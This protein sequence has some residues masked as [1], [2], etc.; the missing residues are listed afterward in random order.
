[1]KLFKL[2]L[3]G[4]FFFSLIG[5]HE[6]YAEDTIATEEHINEY[7]RQ[8]NYPEEIIELFEL[9]Q[10]EDLYNQGAVFIDYENQSE[11]I[12]EDTSNMTL[13]QRQSVNKKIAEINQKKNEI[14]TRSLTN[15]DHV[16]T[17][18]RVRSDKANIAHFVI[19]YNW[20]WN[21]SPIFVMEDKF[22]LSW[23][24]DY[25]IYHNTAKYSYV[26]Y[27]RRGVDSAIGNTAGGQISGYHDTFPGA[28]IS[29]KINLIDAFTKNGQSYDVYRHKG[30]SS[31][32][33][34]KP[35]DGSGSTEQ[36]S[37]AAKYFHKQ[38][39]IAGEITISAPPAINIS[40]AT[41][42]EQSNAFTKTWSWTNTP[43]YQ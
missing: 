16:I 37:M 10:K 9:E 40:Y 26:A 25:D 39:G 2:L 29:W 7:L 18:S 33:I 14:G 4:I 5:L 13:E 27:G 32:K 20:D 36:S 19:N 38:I 31:V 1:M 11:L 8:S 41:S 34:G 12:T 28:G 3:S 35:Q 30:W 43:Y 6:V 15:F 24:D 22:A 42:Y 21:Y 17:I 23:T